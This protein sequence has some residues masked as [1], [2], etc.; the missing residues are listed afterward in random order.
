M[1]DNNTSQIKTILPNQCSLLIGVFSKSKSQVSI[2][3]IS[4]AFAGLFYSLFGSSAN[5]VF[6]IVA[7]FLFFCTLPFINTSLEVLIRKNVDNSIQGRVLSIVSLI[8]QLGMI[9]AFSIAGILADKVFNPL[10]MNDGILAS[11][12]GRVLGIGPGRGIGFMFVLS[13]IMVIIIAFIVSENRI[14]KSLEMK[15]VS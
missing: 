7:G 2:L 5:I 14:I 4:L 6:I 15:A 1:K 9:I 11:T 12:I 10:F 8:S 13:G 3:Y